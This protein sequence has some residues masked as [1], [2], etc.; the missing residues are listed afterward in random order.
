VTIKNIV[1]WIVIPYSSEKTDVSEEQL[2]P[3]LRIEE[4]AKQESKKKTEGLILAGCLLGFL[5]DPDD[6]SNMFLRDIGLFR[7]TRRYNQ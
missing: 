6:G 4:Y 5:S 7:T 3:I 1:S 2:A